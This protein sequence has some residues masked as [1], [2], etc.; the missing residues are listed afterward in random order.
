MALVASEI[1]ARLIIVAQFPALRGSQFEI[2]SEAT[3]V[4]NCIAWAAGDTDKF[5]WPGHFWPR[6]VGRNVTRESFVKAFQSRGYAVC[7][8]PGAEASFEKIALY[9]HNGTP[10]HAARLLP[11]GRWSSKLGRS[12]DISHPLE[13][14]NGDQ[15][16]SPV[17]FMKRKVVD[18]AA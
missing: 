12:H 2:T 8:S 7:D 6:S 10:T 3:T 9:E 17:L 16:G 11:N 18:A 13:G 15:Y 5:W 14:L 1:T 4:Y